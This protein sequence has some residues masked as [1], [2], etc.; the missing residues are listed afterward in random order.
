MR[1]SNVERLRGERRGKNELGARVARDDSNDAFSCSAR[2][3]TMRAPRPVPR[4]KLEAFR[5][6]AAF[7]ANGDG[8]A[9]DAR[10]GDLDPDAARAMA[11]IGVLCG[12]RYELIDDQRGLKW[13]DRPKSQSQA[14]PQRSISHCAKLALR[15]LQMAS[16]Y[17]PTSKR[18][19]S[20]V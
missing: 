1:K 10:R 2:E 9:V 15:S 12:V 20:D 17:L 13:R 19:T 3:R 16:M 8:K 11:L 6:S 7:V 18:S 4:A 5:K 14:A